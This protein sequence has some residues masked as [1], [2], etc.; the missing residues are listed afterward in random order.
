VDVLINIS[1]LAGQYRNPTLITNEWFKNDLVDMLDRPDVHKVLARLTL[2]GN[3]IWADDDHTLYLD[4][5]AFGNEDPPSY[6]NI[7]SGD[8]RCG[9]DF[10]MWFW[11]V[12]PQ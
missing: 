5:E 8:G 4:G 11:L 10:E 3:F 6:L 2:K 7:P 9:G 1:R 12:N